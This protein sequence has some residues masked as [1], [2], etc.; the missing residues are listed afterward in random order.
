MMVIVPSLS[1][2]QDVATTQVPSEA[3][4]RPFTGCF[5]ESTH[6]KLSKAHTSFD[7]SEHRFF[8]RLAQR[9]GGTS[10]RRA[11]PMS[12]MCECSGVGRWQMF[13]R[14]PMSWTPVM[15]FS[16]NRNEW[17][18]A[19]SGD[20][21]DVKFAKIARVSKQR[22]WF[23]NRQVSQCVEHW[24]YLHYVGR[25]LR[26]IC[27]DDEHRVAING[28]LS[29]IGLDKSVVTVHD[30]RVCVCEIYLRVR[31]A[32]DPMSIRLPFKSSSVH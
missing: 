27:G 26:Q 10:C 28:S 30:S 18:D 4:E 32:F 6:Q 24:L 13:R 31:V 1:G 21:L 9:V 11:Q 5:L 19:D 8:G 17:F 3:R 20:A 23:T 2:D 14:F 7:I 16:A 15:R 12:H 22:R 29:I 25:M